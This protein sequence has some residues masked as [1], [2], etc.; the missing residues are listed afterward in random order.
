M[1]SIPVLV[2]AKKEYT[3]QLQQILAPRLYEGLKSIYDDLLI[4]LS[5]EMIENNVQSSSAIKTFQRSLKE[6]PLWNQDMIKNEYNRI[7]K[8]SK[9]DYF[10]NLLEAVFVTNT[11][12]LSSVQLNSN[13]QN[14]KINVPSSSHFVHKCYIECSK[15]LYKNPYIFDMSRGLT[16]KERHSNLRESLNVINHSI[17]NAVR[18][19]LPIREILIQGLLQ[20][21]T[22][23]DVSDEQLN[24]ESMNDESMTQESIND[25]EEEEEEEED[26]NEDNNDK[27]NK[28]ELLND[29]ETHIQEFKTILYDENANDE[30]E[31][32]DE[33]ED[34]ND[35]ENEDENEDDD[36]EGVG[37]PIYSNNEETKT[38]QLGEFENNII[39]ENVIENQMNNLNINNNNIKPSLSDNIINVN[40]NRSEIKQINLEKPSLLRK[41]NTIQKVETP[42]ITE[43]MKPVMPKSIN[44]NPKIQ[45][46]NQKKI[47][48]NK[49]MGGKNNAF[50]QKK[51]DQNLA[52]YHYTSESYLDD[53]E[54]KNMT[55]NN[56]NIDFNSSDEED[57]SP[58]VLS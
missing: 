9:C 3:N 51:Y 10:E 48:K 27:E 32:E 22:Q 34:E 12:I 47:I 50:Y 33:N 36:E 29:N 11:K 35:D 5:N 37:I 26:N 4:A 53:D 56:I 17:S 21:E 39:D 23:N 49:L 45:K 24:Q 7:E 28:I 13:A 30:E 58:V 16:P 54:A 2:E 14:V 38:I 19:M 8:L 46:I 1:N 6:I 44:I 41:I 42:N 15:E 31:N 55:K 20:E 25:E 18:E 40:E 57:N 43:L 52:N